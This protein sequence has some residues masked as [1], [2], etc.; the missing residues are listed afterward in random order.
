MSYAH[1]KGF[2][3]CIKNAV[4]KRCNDAE[5]CL[6]CNIKSREQI[7]FESAGSMSSPVFKKA[8]EWA[9]ERKQNKM[10]QHRKAL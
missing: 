5:T 6:G 8:E 7:V 3:A 9:A 10:L 4:T 2:S 1:S